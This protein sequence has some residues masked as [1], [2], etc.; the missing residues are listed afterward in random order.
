MIRSEINPHCITNG[1]HLK[2]AFIYK[3]ATCN[4]YFEQGLSRDS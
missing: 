2:I 1:E 4:F 3:V